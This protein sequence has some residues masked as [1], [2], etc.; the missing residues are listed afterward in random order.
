MHMYSTY[1]AVRIIILIAQTKQC[2]HFAH[3]HTHYCTKI[4]YKFVPLFELQG[5]QLL[6]LEISQLYNILC[7]C[8]LSQVMTT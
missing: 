6:R 5:G 1:T 7:F 4:V 3:V 2:V 8:T